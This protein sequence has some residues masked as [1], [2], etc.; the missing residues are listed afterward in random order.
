MPA[1]G[2]TYLLDLGARAPSEVSRALAIL[3][4][5]PDVVFAEED[6]RSTAS[7]IPDDPSYSRAGSW[8]Q[9]YDDLYGLKRI[10]TT[11]AWD[12][13]RGDGAVVAVVDTGIDF[14]HPDI[15][16][17]VW[18]N[19]GEIPGN[20]IDD[21]GNGFIDDNRGWD[22]VGA[23]SFDPTPDNDPQDEEGHGSHT[24]GTVAAEG[25]N[26]LGVVGVAWRARVMAV[27]GLDS[28][29][30]GP[31]SALAQCIVYAVDQGADVI[32]ASWGGP[33]VSQVIRDAIDYGY[34]QGVVF[35]AAAGNNHADVSNFQPANAPN[36]LA[37]SALD[38]FDARADFSN[39]GRKVEISAPGVDIL[40]LELGTAGYHRLDG[41]SMATPHVSG[42]VALVLGRHPEFTV[43]QIHQV[44]R[45]T[46]T[47]LGAPGRDDSFGFGRVNAAAA[48]LVD[49][50]LAA[51]IASP[52]EGAIVSG[53]VPVTGSAGGPGFQSYVLERGAGDNPTA[54]TTI[55]TGTTPVASGGVLGT[56]DPFL[57]I[58][59]GLFTLQLRVLS[60]GGATYSD[61]VTVRVQY[62]SIS[63][64]VPSVIPTAAH[65]AKPGAPIPISGR[66]TGPTF[67]RFQIEW[68]PGRDATTGWSTS[69]VSLTGGGTAPVVA[70]VL[71]TWTPSSALSGEH[72]VRLTVDNTGFSSTATTTVYLQ[73]DLASPAWPQA[74]PGAS[75][76][77]QS[78]IPVRQADG[79][80]RLVLCG[81]SLACRSFAPDGS[82]TEIELVQGSEWQ[83]SAGE[84]DPA[85]GQ[86][87]VVPDEPKL[88][89]V[90]ADLTPIRDIVAT[91]GDRFGLEMPS[92]A[93]LDNDGAEEI[94][95]VGRGD[96]FGTA[97]LHV[98]RGNGQPYSSH[99]PVSLDVS[100]DSFIPTVAV[101]LDGNGTKEILLAL[102]EAD[103]QHHRVATFNADGTPYAAWSAPILSG[104]LVHLAA[105][106][107]D[108][109]GRPEVVDRGSG[110]DDTVTVLDARG[111]IRPGWPRTISVG[112]YQHRAL[113]VGDLDRDG[114]DE[115]VV[116]DG[117]GLQLLRSDGSQLG[118]LSWDQSDSPGEPVIADVDGD[119][120]P[121]V[122]TAYAINQVLGTTSYREARLRA[123]SRTGALI[124]EWRLLGA[125]GHRGND[126]V[127]AV[128][129]FL[130]D[131]RTAIA[132]LQDLMQAEGTS[133]VG[134]V[135]RV[136]TTGATYDPTRGQWPLILH[137]PPEQPRPASR[138]D[139]HRP[140]DGGGR[141]L[142]AR[143]QLRRQQLR[144]GHR[145]AG[146]V[147]VL[148]G[149]QPGELSALP[150]H[151]PHRDG[152]FGQAAPLRQPAGR[153]QRHPGGLCR[154]Q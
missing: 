54:W 4:S 75:T 8:G 137:E 105:T 88:R 112:S 120:F 133:F 95:A 59:D 28:A 124:K 142:C 127:P 81:F 82:S 19:P 26:G 114:R 49:Q 2:S 36:A 7:F 70:A 102:P 9:P 14:N 146:Q 1:L 33:G 152:R 37:V 87:L 60:T 89:I 71:G 131:G 110:Q 128:G 150:P 145:P 92:L 16:H 58:G 66:A 109:D 69:G 118:R 84:V 140:A 43:D 101:D 121:D 39:F 98:F 51:R 44:L 147:V 85:P 111:L 97:R 103:H 57:V 83:P 50:V 31:N 126:A 141:R 11:A 48:V 144:D 61:R 73:P 13:A 46:A 17:N 3:R 119:G 47:D 21:D 148:G 12:T 91:N 72:T 104:D 125:A 96:E 42:V 22:F 6:G 65:E 139:V 86:E 90:S 154:R 80:T 78:I 149:D 143:R 74:V 55:A 38:P 53:A 35:V 20:G 62:V 136:L 24:S 56:F 63:S 34:G 41:T 113:A 108:H 99:Y 40:S 134:S 107:L 32:S 25:N 45:T 64:P 94:V 151:R 117:T 77:G 132:I 123:M 115:I 122:V 5:D 30:G 18:T 29:G 68:A 27:K 23:N 138:V 10:G 93:D 52:G 129:D 153:E 76:S 100:G 79:R 135:V 67:Q 130:G 106:D 15:I 116:S